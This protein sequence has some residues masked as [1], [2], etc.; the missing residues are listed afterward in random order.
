MALICSRKTLHAHRPHP[1]GPAAALACARIRRSAVHEAS[2]RYPVLEKPLFSQP[3]A[4]GRSLSHATGVPSLYLYSAL[5]DARIP[6]LPISPASPN[7]NAHVER[8]IQSIQRE[9]LDHFLV[10]GDHHLRHLIE[11][12][13]EYYNTVRPHPGVGN[14]ALGMPPLDYDEPW[15]ENLE[16]R[17]KARL[18]G[19]LRHYR[20]VA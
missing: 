15:P 3:Y 10:F 4:R 7:L 17:C 1:A 5:K 2:A 20:L 9:C 12:C 6:M 19:L 18:G 8:W 13:V 16:V 14:R 11:G